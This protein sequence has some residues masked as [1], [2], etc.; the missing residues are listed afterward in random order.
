MQLFNLS[1]LFTNVT[2]TFAVLF[3]FFEN[4]IFNAAA[5]LRSL[6]PKARTAEMCEQHYS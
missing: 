6:L 3:I 2:T 1:G 4:A 5:A